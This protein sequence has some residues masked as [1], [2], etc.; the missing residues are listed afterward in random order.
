MLLFRQLELTFDTRKIEIASRD[1]SAPHAGLP[2]RRDLDLETMARELVQQFGA[3]S[4]AAKVRV[5]WNGRLRTCA[6]RADSRHSLI[7]L[8]PRLHEH[9]VAEIDRTFRHELAPLLAQF[10]AGRRR[11]PPHGAEWRQACRDLG[12]SDETRC[13]SL[14]FPVKRRLRRYHYQC[15]QCRRD[16][17]RVRRIRRTTACLACCH[18]YNRGRF[19]ARF[20]LTLRATG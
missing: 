3:D 2:G 8:N 9:A 11:I 20:R 7:S 10:G 18:K 14:P 4:L 6:G 16:F 15:P 1:G 12:I 19:D 13:H 5:E 17:P